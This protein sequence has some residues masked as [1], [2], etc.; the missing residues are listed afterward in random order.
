MFCSSR[1]QEMLVNPRSS[2]I[3]PNWYFS[4]LLSYW[5][6]KWNENKLSRYLRTDFFAVLGDMAQNVLRA[7]T[8]AALDDVDKA[9][10]EDAVVWRFSETQQIGR[11]LFLATFA[12]EVG[13]IR[14]PYGPYVS[15]HWK[16]GISQVMGSGFSHCQ[17]VN[18]YEADVEARRSFW[19]SYLDLWI[20]VNV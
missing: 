11:C 7:Q 2:C 9:L 17:V 10:S 3:P 8:D 15:H 20:M 5:P 16:G 4:I 13:W 12:I 19:I 1:L 6:K 18:Q 14:Q